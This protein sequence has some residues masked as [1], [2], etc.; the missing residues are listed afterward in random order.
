MM[1]GKKIIN[2]AAILAAALASAAVLVFAGLVGASEISVT[3][4]LAAALQDSLLDTRNEIIDYLNS[5]SSDSPFFDRVELRT[6]TERFEL[7]R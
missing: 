4:F 3:D 5:T 1:S 2:D 7:S 6:Q